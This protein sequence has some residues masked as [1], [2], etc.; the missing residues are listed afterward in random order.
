M[1]II[2][3]FGAA[4]LALLLLF[5]FL[6]PYLPGQIDPNFIHYDASGTLMKNF[7]MGE[8]GFLFGTDNLGRDV[9]SRVWFG[10][11]TSLFIGFV[12]ALSECVIGITVGVLWGYVR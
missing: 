5:T 1:K 6:Q 8:Q 11:R 10:I 9:W 12:V 4:L 3:K 7:A 2:K